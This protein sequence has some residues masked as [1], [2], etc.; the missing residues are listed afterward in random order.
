MSKLTEFPQI[1][2]VYGEILPVIYENKDRYLLK[3]DLLGKDLMHIFE[4]AK[5]PEEIFNL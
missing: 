4:H 2:N 3:M 5:N 1:P